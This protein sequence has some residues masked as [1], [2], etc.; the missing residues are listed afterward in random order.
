MQGTDGDE[1]WRGILGIE[2]GILGL[3]KSAALELGPYNVTL[4]AILPAR[5]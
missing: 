4:N 3:M 1:T 5:H 2:L